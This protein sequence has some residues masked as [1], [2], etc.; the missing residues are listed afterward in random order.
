MTTLRFDQHIVTCVLVAFIAIHCGCGQRAAP[1]SGVTASPSKNDMTNSED[2]GKVSS[3]AQVAPGTPLAATDFAA[4]LAATEADH[5]VIQVFAEYCG[6]CM[7]EALALN[8]R[9][10]AWRQ[11]GIAVLGLGMDETPAS[12]VAFHQQ[13]GRRI[14]FPLYTAPW[15]AEQQ[16]I[17]LTPTLFIYDHEGQQ[18]FRADAES[19]PERVLEAI[20][21][22]LK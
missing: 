7:T 11:R 8:D 21:D 1:S 4:V 5:V 14:Q 2:D 13:T 18:L 10:D 22:K 19:H 15:F 17:A 3:Q 20:E 6:P 16:D 12:V 9:L